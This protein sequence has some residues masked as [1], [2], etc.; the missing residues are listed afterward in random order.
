MSPH[1]LRDA[2]QL[3]VRDQFKK[4]AVEYGGE[5]VTSEEYLGIDPGRIYVTVHST[6]DEAADLCH[7]VTGLARHRIYR[8]DDKDDF[9]HMGDTEL[10]WDVLGDLRGFEGEE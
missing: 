1:V 3:L 7:N 6:N 5:W 4:E 10:V 2:R 9:W 8:L